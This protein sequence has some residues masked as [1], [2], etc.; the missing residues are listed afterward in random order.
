MRRPSILQRYASLWR[1]NIRRSTEVPDG[2]LL[3]KSSHLLTQATPSVP[4]SSRPGLPAP[5]ETI[6]RRA[7]ESFLPFTPYFRSLPM[8]SSSAP[9]FTSLVSSSSFHSVNR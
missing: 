2:L 4:C 5:A 7:F 9:F 8:A 3:N 1:S 6:G